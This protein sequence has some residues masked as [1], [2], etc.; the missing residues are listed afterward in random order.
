MVGLVPSGGGCKEMLWRWQQATGDPVEAARKTFGFIGPARSAS[1]PLE[2]QP[3]LLFRHEDRFTMNR[4][5]LLSEARRW[6][7]ELADGYAPPDGPALRRAGSSGLQVL[8][9]DLQD[10][11]DRGIA[12]AHDLTVGRALANVLCG[13]EGPSGEILSE[14]RI[15]ALERENFIQLAGTPETLARIEHTLEQGRPLRN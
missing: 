4:D 1:S 13:G 7:L 8:A 6:A 14:E 12:T 9:A 10:L 2:A 3:L 5:R 15:C 11:R